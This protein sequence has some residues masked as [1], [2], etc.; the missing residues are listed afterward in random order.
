MNKKSIIITVV[1]ALVVGAGA[2]Y[3]GTAYE[4]NSLNTQG[5]L[6]NANSQLGSRQGGTQGG[7][8]PGQPGQG[9]RQQGGMMGGAGRGGNGGGFAVGQIIAKDDTSITI[10]GPDGSSK[11]I[12]FSGSTQVG[13]I[14]Q[15]SSND[16]VVGQMITTNGQT[17][18]D[19][20]IAA[21]SIQIRPDKPVQ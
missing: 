18:A 16:L 5:L 7:G 21:Q 6:R 11:S 9:G 20:S 10:K 12:F 8:Q 3:G 19:G 13:K 1:V 4:K 14:A 2:F 15:G 17:N